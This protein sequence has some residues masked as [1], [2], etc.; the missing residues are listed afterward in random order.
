MYFVVVV[1][2]Q[3]EEDAV[4]DLLPLSLQEERIEMLIDY[5]AVLNFPTLGIPSEQLEENT[6]MTRHSVLNQR[7][8]WQRRDGK[9]QGLS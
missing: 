3:M 6:V 5:C 8:C 4:E 1:V 2:V 9:P 7:V